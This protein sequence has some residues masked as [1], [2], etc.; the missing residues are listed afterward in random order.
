M[1]STENTGRGDEGS[2]LI[3]VRA[4][5]RMLGRSI[6]SIFRDDKAGRIPRPLGIGGSK[7][8]RRKEILLWVNSG[9]PD[10]SAWEARFPRQVVASGAVLA[11]RE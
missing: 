9:C 1:T 6:S 5:A 11:R 7:R 4:L 8:W 10:R 3:D 2:L